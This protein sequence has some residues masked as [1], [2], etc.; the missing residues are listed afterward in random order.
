MKQPTQEEYE[1]ALDAVR[2][3]NPGTEIWEGSQ[4]KTGD[5]YVYR[6]ATKTQV[7]IFRKLTRAERDKGE[8][9]DFDTPNEML[10]M[11]C[12]LWPPMESADP[13]AVTLPKLLVARP[14]IS[15]AMADDIVE[16][17]GAGERAAAKKL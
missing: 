5:R 10:A 16:V 11:G 15:A 4:P 13:D 3:A 17:S 12:V 14:M 9:A 1:K 8:L 7:K 2:A 6:A